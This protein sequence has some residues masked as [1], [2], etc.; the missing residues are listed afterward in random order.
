MPE[1]PEVETV[2]RMLEGA[3]VGRVVRRATI[4]GAAL[5]GTVPRTLPRRLAGRRIETV[6]RRGKYLLIHFDADLTLLAHLGMSGRWLFNERAPADELPHVHLRIRFADRSELWYQDP[7]RFGLLRAVARGRLERDPSLRILGPDPLASPPTAESL[8][9]RARGARVS[10]KSFLLDQRRIAGLGNIYV[11][12]VLHRAAIDPRRRAGSLRDPEWSAVAGQVVAVLAE[13]VEG[14]GTTFDAYRTLWNQPGSYGERLLVYDRAG[15]PCRRCKTPIRRI[16]QGA[17][18]TFFCPT[19]QRRTP[20]SRASKAKG[21][22]R[23]ARQSRA[24]ASVIARRPPA[25]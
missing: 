7:R 10:V 19:C 17:R 23:R 5:R 18:S 25:P 16:V 14:F 13:A 1:L 24:R 4:S 12:E 6:Q 11:S 20:A 2:R 3:V 15:E 9:G 22:P 8:G 21:T